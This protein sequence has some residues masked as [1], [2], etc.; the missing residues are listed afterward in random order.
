MVLWV[1][2][3]LICQL[4]QCYM[5]WRTNQC[6]RPEKWRGDGS[7]KSHY[8]LCGKCDS[9][10][11]V[12]TGLHYLPCFPLLISMEQ[13]LLLLGQSDIWY[14]LISGLWHE[15]QVGSG[16][17]GV[18]RVRFIRQIVHGGHKRSMKCEGSWSLCNCSRTGKRDFAECKR[19][20]LLLE[21]VGEFRKETLDCW[22]VV[23]EVQSNKDDLAI[24]I[25][26]KHV[27]YCHFTIVL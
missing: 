1:N 17:S 22:Q 21:V 7:V 3:I 18:G 6:S 8:I 26:S 19:Y 12:T 23:T 4:L 20:L 24:V 14:L 9:Y 15:G 5:E 13:E 27:K 16:S 11:S 2:L 25:Y 10:S